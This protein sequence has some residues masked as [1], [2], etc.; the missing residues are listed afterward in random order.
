MPSISTKRLYL[1]RAMYLLLAVGLG[2]SIWPSI[3][4]P[5]VAAADSKTVVR[6]L[7]GAVG[8]LASLGLL[9]PLRMIPLLLFELLWKTIWLLAF[10]LPLWIGNALD[11]NST[12]NACE[13]LA[14]VVLVILATPWDYVVRTYVRGAGDPWRGAAT[15]NS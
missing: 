10:A 4:F 8:A 1:L 13:C 7:L 3:V 12:A 5:P 2:L 9:H 6:A 11:A 14:G 15:G